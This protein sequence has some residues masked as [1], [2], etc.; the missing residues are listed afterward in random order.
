MAKYCP[1]CGYKNDDDA[2]NCASCMA[3]LAESG[4]IPPETPENN[5]KY[6]QALIYLRYYTII[7]F[8]SL[9]VG[10]II[11]YVFLRSFSYGYLVGPLGAAFGGVTLNTSSV[12][13]LIAYSEIAL[14]VSAVLTIIGFFMLYRGFT[15]LKVLDPQFSTGRT[16]TILEMVGMVLVVLGTL[17]LLATV[18]PNVNLG[19]TTATST[20]VQSELGALLGL[21]FLILAAAIILLVGIIMAL[22]G[23]FR[24]GSRFDSTVVKVG[25]VLTVFLG[26]IGTI[27]L[28][29]GFSE[30]INKLR[31]NTEE[32]GMV[33]QL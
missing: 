32:P 12:S 14:T 4:N 19:N 9:V 29:I 20:L 30:I 2:Q 26:I 18:L 13:G 3:P 25:A 22:I 24:V 6:L 10:I 7:G 15:S 33:E 17:G 23:I 21:A 1:K 27:L 11:N 5:R 31:R 16:G 8:V 28:F